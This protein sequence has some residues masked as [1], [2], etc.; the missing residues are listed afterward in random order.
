MVGRT[1][2]VI[3]CAGP[4]STSGSQLSPPVVERKDPPV[5]PAEAPP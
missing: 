1:A 4:T 5:L 3:P 2:C